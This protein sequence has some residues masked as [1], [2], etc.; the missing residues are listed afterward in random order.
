MNINNPV[1]SIMTTEVTSV[2]PSQ[3]LIDVKHIFEKK[4]FHHHI[5]VVEDGKLVGMISLI[6]YMRA[7]KDA[8]LDDEESIYQECA[9]RD[10]MSGSPRVESSE[11]SI[12]KIAEELAKGDVHAIAIADNNKLKGIVSTADIIRFFLS[13]A[14]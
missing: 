9:V 6:D 8:T 11:T 2:A 12:R 4:N 10:I 1:S 13:K 3:K 5:P 14:E 7:I